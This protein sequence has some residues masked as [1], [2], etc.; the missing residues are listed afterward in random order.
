MCLLRRRSLS[1]RVP[2]RETMRARVPSRLTTRLSSTPLGGCDDKHHAPNGQGCHLPQRA[3]R[4]V[5]VPERLRASLA[6]WARPRGRHRQALEWTTLPARASPAFEAR[7]K[8][9]KHADGVVPS[10]ATPRRAPLPREKIRRS[11]DCGLSSQHHPYRRDDH[12]VRG[13]PTIPSSR[14]PQ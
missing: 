6:T 4:P 7:S 12:A 2:S 1:A 9:T 14:V 8:S 10:G 11:L 3:T 5:G 13:R